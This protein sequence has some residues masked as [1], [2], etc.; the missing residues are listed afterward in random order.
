MFVILCSIYADES[1]MLGLMML[2][3]SVAF[4]DSSLGF[5]NGPMVLFVKDIVRVLAFWWGK[6]RVK[7]LWKNWSRLQGNREYDFQTRQV[8]LTKFGC[9]FLQKEQLQVLEGEIRTK[10]VK[11]LK[12]MWW[13]GKRTT[14]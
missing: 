2:C 5:R 13:F 7:W 12:K 6:E 10:K 1:L 3:P 11:Y 9:E 14:Q 8:E 4:R